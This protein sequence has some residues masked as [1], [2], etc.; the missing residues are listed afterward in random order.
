MPRHSIDDKEETAKRLELA[1]KQRGYDTAESACDAFGWNKN[2]YQAHESGSRSYARNATTYAR[3]FRVTAGWL[4]FG[5]TPPQWLDGSEL[6]PLDTDTLVDSLKIPLLSYDDLLNLFYNRID[7]GSLMSKKQLIS[8]PQHNEYLGQLICLH[9]D[10]K[11]NTIE[12]SSS[13]DI[14]VDMG[15]KG[16]VGNFV[17]VKTPFDTQPQVM[18]IIRDE[19]STRRL[20]Y[21]VDNGSAPIAM[22]QDGIE[23]IGRVRQVIKNI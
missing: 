16:D 21:I 10:Q 14:V 2:T 8:V 11:T 20:E 18:K 7:I 12:I 6:Q 23:I 17:V 13:D 22:E 5:E 3:A 19:N 15:S 1:R 4:M 9:I